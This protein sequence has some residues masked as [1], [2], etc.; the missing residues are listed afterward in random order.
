MLRV[1]E[2]EGLVQKLGTAGK[3]RVMELFSLE[4]HLRILEKLIEE[5]ID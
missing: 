1:L 5:I 3:K 2:E 4:K